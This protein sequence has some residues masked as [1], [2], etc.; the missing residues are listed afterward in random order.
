MSRYIPH[1]FTGMLVAAVAAL[2]TGVTLI[3]ISR[4]P[5]AFVAAASFLRIGAVAGS[6]VI[7]WRWSSASPDELDDL[8]D[9]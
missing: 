2:A 3:I 5:A 9:E 4:E 7:W 8:D 6:L 1:S